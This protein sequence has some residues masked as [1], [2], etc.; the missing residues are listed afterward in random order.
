MEPVMIALW[1]QV[2]HGGLHFSESEVQLDEVG[3]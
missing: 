3:V 1:A 2:C